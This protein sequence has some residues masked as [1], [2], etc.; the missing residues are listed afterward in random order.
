MSAS[1]CKCGVYEWVH[2]EG[3]GCGNYRKASRARLWLLDHSIYSHVVAPVWT[4]MPEKWRWSV[5]Y[6][7]DKS[8]RQC[9]SDLVSDA[10]THRED[11][12]CDTHIPRLIG[13]RAPACAS[14]CDWSHFDHA[15]EHPCSCYCGKFQFTATDGAIERRQPRGTA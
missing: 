15:G 6:W 11:D 10:L 12:A 14:V 8:R 2:I 3:R 9:W 1:R 13:T 7:L 5:V 4:R